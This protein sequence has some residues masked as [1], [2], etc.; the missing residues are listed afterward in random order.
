MVT[1]T[2]D[3]SSKNIK[4]LEKFCQETGSYFNHNQIVGKNHHISISLDNLNVDKFSKLKRDLDLKNE[5]I[6]KYR[7][8]KL[9]N[10]LN[11]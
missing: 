11:I 6:W 10:L 9:S 3:I 7:L 2:T 5:N 8:K 1:I 4:D